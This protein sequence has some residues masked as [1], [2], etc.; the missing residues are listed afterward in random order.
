MPL[1]VKIDKKA[2]QK[3]LLDKLNSL[4]RLRIEKDPVE[5]LRAIRNQKRI[6]A[7]IK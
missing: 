1:F 5:I 4:S 2:K 7:R 6:K 3:K